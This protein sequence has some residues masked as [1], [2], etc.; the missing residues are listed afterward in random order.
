MVA[1]AGAPQASG[2]GIA[3]SSN[4]TTSAAT[5]TPPQIQINGDNP[6]VIQVSATYNDLGAT[7]TGP[8]ADLNLDIHT[9]LNGTA[10]SPVQIDTSAAATDTIDYVVTD[11][12]GL[13]S[14]STRTVI[15]KAPSIIPSDDTATTTPIATTTNATPTQATT[16]AQ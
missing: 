8:Q 12:N 4:A 13:T 1:A 9:F 14:T 5:D 3:P 16:T 7:I 15:V 2:G 11:Q 10:I 6:A